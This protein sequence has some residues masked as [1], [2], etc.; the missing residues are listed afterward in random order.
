MTSPLLILK[1]GATFPALARTLGDFDDWIRAGLGTP[2]LDIHVADARRDT[3]P[4]PQ[5]LA[6]VVITGSHAMVTDREPWS[7]TAAAWLR[8]AVQ[9]GLPVLGICYGHQLLAHC[10]GGEVGYHAGGI[11]VGSVA[12]QLQPAAGA[13]PV[14]GDLPP[15]F[16]A[17]VVHRQSVHALPDGAV[18]LAGN[19]FEPNQAF[20]VGPAAWGVQFHPEFSAPAMRAYVERLAPELRDEG[21]DPAALAAGVVDTPA[22][23]RV[24]RNFARHVQVTARPQ[25][26]E[27]PGSGIRPR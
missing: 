20:R 16:A 9:A 10:L 15:V 7:E 21:H 4:A 8:G 12:V 6:G 11:E 27:S 22:A 5:T 19:A 24:L 23:A 13:D 1:A 26:P 17:Q 14:F 3:L 2:G 18:Q 25:T